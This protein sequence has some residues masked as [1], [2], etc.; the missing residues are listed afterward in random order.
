MSSEECGP[1]VYQ[2][3]PLFPLPD[4][5]LFPGTA[6]PLRIFESRYMAMVRDAL[7]GNEHIGVVMLRDHEAAT[8][9]RAAIHGTACL[10]QIVHKEMDD[11]DQLHILVHGIER[12]SLLEEMALGDQGYRR[13]LAQRVPPPS[14]RMLEEA[15][16]DL[17][18]LHA[19]ALTLQRLIGHNDQQLATLICNTTNPV[20]L[21]DILAAVLIHEPLERQRVLEAQNL[22]LRVRLLI[23][24]M[25]EV[26][27]RLGETP[28]QERLN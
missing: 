9:Q 2:G 27:I 26:M 1:H 11:D 17:M 20:Q 5:V 22:R 16:T 25:S 18:R 6:L 12:V 19:C 23:D 15:H 28:E 7:H 13:F 8:E 24:A 21:T 10:A 3:L 14:S 4:T